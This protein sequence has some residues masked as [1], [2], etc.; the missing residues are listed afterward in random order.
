MNNFRKFFLAVLST[1]LVIGATSSAMAAN[2][3]SS[4]ENKVKSAQNHLAASQRQ[5]ENAQQRYDSKLYSNASALD[6]QQQRILDAE[7]NYYAVV[8][9]SAAYVKAA[10]QGCLLCFGS[11]YLSKKIAAAEARE[12]SNNARA[13]A[14]WNAL[15]NGL[16]KFILSQQ[17]QLASIQRTI[18]RAAEKVAKDEIILALALAN[19]A[20]CLN[21]PPATPPT[22]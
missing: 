15:K 19:L 2:K 13:L 6:R 5:L 18:D 3:C 22:P 8:E 11:A 12:R 14:R 17:R 10:K 16:P 21:P 9:N 7:N 20:S 1:V 4:Q